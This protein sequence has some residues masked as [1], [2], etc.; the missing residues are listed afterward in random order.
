MDEIKVLLVDDHPVVR[1]GYRRLLD[2]IPN[3]QVVAEAETGAEGYRKYVESRPDVVVMDLSLPDIGGLEVIRKILMRD[4]AAK[5]LV[6]SVHENEILVERALEAGARGYLTKRSAPKILVH[7]LAAV[8]HGEIYLDP[9]LH[10]IAEK[11]RMGHQALLKRLTSREFE[12]FRHLAEGRS[13]AEIAALLHASAKTIGVHQTRI[14][15]KL[16]LSNAVQLAHIAVR[17]GIIIP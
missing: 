3:I 10:G 4:S 11:A 16:N 13:V 2:N 15:K 7:A 12:V 9:A 1:S 14:M 5:I 8:A 17:A 6:F